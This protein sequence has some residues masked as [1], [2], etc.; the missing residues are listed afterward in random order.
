M[1]TIPYTASEARKKLYTLIKSAS[2]GLRTYE[3]RLRGDDEPVILISKSEL[4][5]WQETL[6]ILG[7][8]EEIETVRRGRKTKKTISH[9]KMLELM[10]FSK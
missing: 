3:I 10:G 7:N 8:K 5:S 9:K 1:D 4:E 2:E 6:D